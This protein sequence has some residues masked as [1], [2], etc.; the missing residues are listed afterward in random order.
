[1]PSFGRSLIWTGEERGLFS[2]QGLVPGPAFSVT[3]DD[4]DPQLE[5]SVGEAAIFLRLDAC[6]ITSPGLV[7]G[8][9][10]ETWHEWRELWPKEM[11]RLANDAP[12]KSSVG[13]FSI[14]HIWLK[15]L[16][17]ISSFAASLILR[18][19]SAW[20]FLLSS[21]VRLKRVVL[22]PDSLPTVFLIFAWRE[23]SDEFESRLFCGLSAW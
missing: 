16:S 2:R 18:L 22:F 20:M 12:S 19:S 9:D 11:S 3:D 8:N 15:T 21:R 1:M 10:L 17:P 4:D 13:E 5:L 6:V 7:W 14:A 23:I